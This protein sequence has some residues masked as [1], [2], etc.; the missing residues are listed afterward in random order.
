MRTINETFTDEEHTKL[1]E[2]KKDM[3]WHDFILARADINLELR[4]ATGTP[5]IV[6]DMLEDGVHEGMALKARKRASDHACK[7]KN[8]GA[9]R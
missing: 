9:V 3:S 8:K 5:Q 6:E 1:L 7:V 4:K 2:A